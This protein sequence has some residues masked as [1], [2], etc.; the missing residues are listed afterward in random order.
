[1]AGT[2]STAGPT[3]D[4]WSPWNIVARSQFNGTVAVLFGVSHILL[5]YSFGAD[6]LPAMFVLLVG[7]SVFLWVGVNLFLG[8]DAFDTGWDGH[9]IQGWMHV[10]FLSILALTVTATSVAVF[11]TG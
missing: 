9:D 3:S 6:D 2:D 5:G 8:N 7:G 10:V 1:M 4:E 11:L